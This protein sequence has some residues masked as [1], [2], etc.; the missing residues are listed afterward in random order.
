MHVVVCFKNY[1]VP[2]LYPFSIGVHQKDLMKYFVC[3]CF[4]VVTCVTVG[5]VVNKETVTTWSGFYSH[6]IVKVS[7]A[8]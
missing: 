7:D 2:I 6:Q 8:L 1:R 5:F 4:S 3:K